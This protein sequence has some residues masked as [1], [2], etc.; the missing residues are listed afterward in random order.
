MNDYYDLGSY[1]RTIS[2]SSSEAQLWFDRGLTWTYGF[3]HEEAIECFNKALEYDPDCVM[4][5]WGIAYASGPNYNKKWIDFEDEEKQ[6][7]LD[8]ANGL[9]RSAKNRLDKADA[10]ESGL[11]EALTE[12][13][14]DDARTEDFGPWNDAF[15]NAMRKVYQA[16]PEDLDVCTL[17]A[18][19][20][21]NRTPWELWDLP[22]GKPAEG[23]DTE[24][25]IEVLETAFEKLA[26]KGSKKHPG[27][28]HMYL[29]LMEMSP[30][31]E[32]ALSVGDALID[33]VPDAGHL[34]HMP[35]HV[36][37]LCGDYQNVV[38]RNH[39]AIQADKKYLD[40][41]GP[42]NFYTLY[43][44]HNYHFK[45]YGAMF[46]GQRQV[47]LDTADELAASLPP[48]VVEP[49]ADWVEGFYPMKQHV[50]IRF[51]EWEQIKQQPLPE[52]PKLYAFTLALIHYA[53][54]VAHA[55]TG[56]IPAAE[57]AREDY[58]A[59]KAAMPETRTIFNNLCVDIL[60]V[61][62]A[63]LEGELSYRKGDFEKAFAHLRRS[64]EL[65]DN[66][67]YDEPWGWMQP[68]R[69]ALGALLMEQ[70]R[71]DE[72]EAVYRADLGFDNTLARACQH[73]GNVWSLHGLHECLTRQGRANEAML[74]KPALDKALARADVQI[75]YSCYCRG[76]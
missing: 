35:T 75:R 49:L 68:T 54:T 62:E 74:I 72:A 10:I 26:D 28:L 8:A 30:H 27:L 17:F 14:P 53:K 55:A 3:H 16:H 31:P 12:R 36:D 15:A 42:F 4:A 21:M 67:P 34:Q 64:V 63:M 19:S 61:A 47:A 71:I 25:A 9:V 58:H 52:N 11:I 6:A 5:H 70:D 29:H 2:T 45:I 57:A 51:G 44:C 38:M 41:S 40:R 39:R 59:A 56:D 50:L 32:K 24:E 18:E 43:R 37:V 65:D 76:M 7:C 60:A 69:H 13:Y 73:P 46:I 20:M 1:S 23:A 33:L 66:L 48:E 22:T